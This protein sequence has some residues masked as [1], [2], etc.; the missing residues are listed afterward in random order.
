VLDPRQEAI[1]IADKQNGQL[2]DRTPKVL[3]YDIRAERIDVLFAGSSRSYPYGHDRIAILRNPSPVSLADGMRVEV[4]GVVWGNVTE[5]LTFAGPQGPWSRV[6]YIRGKADEEA[7]RTY[8]ADQVRLLPDGARVGGAV[9][10]LQYWRAIVDR[11]PDDDYLRQPYASLGFVHPESVL[12]RY[13]SGAPGEHREA[14]RPSPIFPFHGNLSQR[15]AVDNALRRSVSVIEGPPGT[16]KT[17]TIL[18]LVANIVV[19]GDRSIGVVSLNNAAVD[20]VREKFE[21]SGFGYVIANLGKREKRDAF[22]TAQDAR[23]AQV[24]REL[25]VAH[26]GSPSPQSIADRSPTWPTDS[27]GCNAMSAR[28]LSSK[29]SWWLFAWSCSISTSTSDVQ[30]CRI[31]SACHCCSDRPT[32]FSTIWSKANWSGRVSG[33]DS[34]LGSADTSATG[35][36]AG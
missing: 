4:S 8:P 33:R 20:N 3:H 10:V 34:L 25:G 18:N 6:F 12:G 29:A 21:E 7:Y 28:E 15:E 24:I 16:G 27:K 19:A 1:L 23:N 17:E 30:N 36:C 9:E 13:L 14:P 32:V 35:R 26:D 31:W 2:I 22:L 5:I 11:L